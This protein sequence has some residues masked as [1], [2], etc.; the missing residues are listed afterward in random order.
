LSFSRRSI[1]GVP[2]AAIAASSALAGDAGPSL[3]A[4]L[5]PLARFVGRWRG[6]REG[7]PGVSTI[8]RSYEPTLGGR[9]L[10]CRSRSTYAPQAKNPKGE[11][12][13]DLGVFSFDAG[14]KRFRFRQFHTEGFVNQYVGPGETPADGTLVFDSEAIEN[15]APGW[16][17]RESYRFPSADALEE[18]FELS[19]PSSES[20]A[21][22]SRCTLNRV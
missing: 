2:L 17:A 1:L 14:L 18:V 4:R 19:E 10:L 20:Y 8:E 22:Y 9:F 15:I 3:H 11:V 21:V 13:E 12:H 7:E 16:R 6:A 5:A